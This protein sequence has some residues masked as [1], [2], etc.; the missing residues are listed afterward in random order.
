MGSGIAALPPEFVLGPPL[1]DSFV[2]EPPADEPPA[3][4]LCAEEPPAEEP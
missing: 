3:E 2:D 4:E 1:L